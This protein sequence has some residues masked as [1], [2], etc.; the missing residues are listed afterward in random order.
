MDAAALETMDMARVARDIPA[1]RALA[2]SYVAAHR[3]RMGSAYT[4][5]TREELVGLVSLLRQKGDRLA[6]LDIEAWLLAEYE[7]QHI[8]GRVRPG[9]A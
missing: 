3:D 5:Y 4:R 2:K 8:T 9:G 1:A 6:Q 7:P